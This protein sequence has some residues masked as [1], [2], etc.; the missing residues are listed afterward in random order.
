MSLLAA[1]LFMVMQPPAATPP[2]VD[3]DVDVGQFE[4]EDFP[5]V[6][7][8]ARYLPH[9][10]M[11]GRVERMIADG[12][13]T[14]TGV[15]ARRFNIV[16]PFAI[17]M[18]ADGTPNSVVVKESG[19]ASLETLAGQIVVAQLERGDFVPTHRE[20]ERWYV[21]ELAFAMG[22]EEQATAIAMEDP[23][24]MICREAAPELGSRLRMVRDCRTA[25][26]WRTYAQDR[27]Q[28]R[29][30]IADG[31][32]CGAPCDQKRA[33]GADRKWLFSPSLR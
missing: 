28:L 21:S 10:D 32:S 5:E 30:D 14:L 25:A 27:E 11:V 20:G 12:R 9:S 16:V 24:R 6:V 13:C 15:S 26:Q 22:V 3:V 7:Q 19:C 31:V 1:L 29:R 23:G 17:L 8:L 2:R 4:P 33:S 18:E